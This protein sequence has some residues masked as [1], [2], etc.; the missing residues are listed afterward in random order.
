MSDKIKKF[1]DFMTGSKM[2]RFMNHLVIEGSYKS[3]VYN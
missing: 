2:R 3:W 1:N